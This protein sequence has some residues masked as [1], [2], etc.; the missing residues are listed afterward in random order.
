MLAGQND[1]LRF[2]S[3]LRADA[4]KETAIIRYLGYAIGEI[5]LVVV[6][7]LIA[8]QINNWAEDRAARRFELASLEQIHSNLEADHAGLQAMFDDSDQAVAST[9]KILALAGDPSPPDEL[10]RWI[11]DVSQFERFNA[12]TNAYETLR[13]RGLDIVRNEDLR[14]TLG[15]YYDNWAVEILEHYGDLEV[16]FNT[17]WVPLLISEFEDFRWREFARP[18][19][20][21]A[22]LQ[23][24][25][26]LATLRL[27]QS[28]H[29]GAADQTA[30]MMA[31]NTK[32][33]SLIRE[34]LARDTGSASE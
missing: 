18:R 24:R 31:V 3:R 33:R 7:I 2:F 19:D 30:N 16:A 1:L 12:I 26:F 34:E 9:K 23:N 29:Q 20:P 32:L 17:L 8:L 13:S 25:T 6:G 21:I 14:R 10:Q 5:A 27:Q 11:A 15:V 4:L 28:N 22:L